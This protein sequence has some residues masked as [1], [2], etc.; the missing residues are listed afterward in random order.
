MIE[1]RRIAE[2]LREWDNILVV[3]HA[4]PDGDT[5]GS[6]AA[7]LRLLRALGKRIS[8]RCAD[9]IPAKYAFLFEGLEFSA[10]AASKIIAVDVAD[11]RLLGGL[12][13]EFEGKINLA[14]DHHGTHASFAETAYIEPKSGANAEII[15]ELFKLMNIPIDKQAADC[16]YAGITT[17]TGG[18]RYAN[19][20]PRSHRIAAELMESGADAAELNYE[21]LIVKTRRQLEAEMEAMS[22]LEFFRGGEIALMTVSRELMD[23]LGLQNDDIDALSAKPRQIEGVL[24]GVTLKEKENGS[25]KVSVRTNKNA[26]AAEICKKLGGGGHKGAAGAEIAAVGLEAAKRRILEAAEEYLES[27][28]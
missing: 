20:T 1:L 22:G 26:N 25:F 16:L 6:A 8:F 9:E 12:K 2:I 18:F 13:E 5:L 4:S 19:T 11:I 21:L 14:I 28:L 10:D 24:V 15:F 17:D 7:L 27:S 23:R 3:S